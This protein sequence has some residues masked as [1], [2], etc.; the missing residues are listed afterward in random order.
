MTFSMIGFILVRFVFLDDLANLF[1]ATRSDNPT[2][3]LEGQLLVQYIKEVYVYDCLSIPT[4][5]VT[6]CVLGIL[7]GYGKTFLSTILNFSRIATR[8]IT[9]T[10]LFYAGMD[11]TAVGVAM[12]VSNI[13]IMA[14][15]IIF[16]VIFMLKENP[17]KKQEMAGICQE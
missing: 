8:I 5:G 16:F 1:A 17:L 2:E 7:Y 3:T 9:L 14:L 11:Y 4:L 12:G 10:A 6:S 13:I 15:S